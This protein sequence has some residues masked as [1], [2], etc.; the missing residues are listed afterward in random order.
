MLLYR[1]WQSTRGP[2][3]QYTPGQGEEDLDLPFGKIYKS[4]DG[5]ISLH[6]ASSKLEWGAIWT[7]AIDPARP[8]YGLRRDRSWRIQNLGWRP[9]VGF[10]EPTASA[11]VF[12]IALDPQNPST[13]YRGRWVTAG[14]SQQRFTKARMGAK[15]GMR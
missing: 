2:R 14:H 8:L 13:I 1:L 15:V 3:A 12:S 4:V 9:D 5:G 6:D 11:Q 10:D 7:L